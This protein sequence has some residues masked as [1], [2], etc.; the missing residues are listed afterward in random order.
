MTMTKE[1]G[2]V[3]F[4]GGVNGVGKSSFLQELSVRHPEFEI[5][6]GSTKFMECLGIEPGDY[7]TM[8][9]LPDDYKNKE[10]DK[11]MRWVLENGVLSEKTLIIDAHYYNYK[12]GE[13][14][15]ATGDWIS[16]LD[17]LFV[18]S[19]S[20]ATILRRVELDEIRSGHKR[21]LL[22]FEAE[23]S[24]KIELLDKFLRMT[25]DKAR[26]LSEK[27]G[28]PYFVINN[29]A[30]GVDLAVDEFLKYHSATR[31]VQK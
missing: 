14:I 23:E 15:N 16:L 8:R 21:D 11:M 10:L 26:E 13:M 24:Q 1:R 5:F 7:E 22:P 29:D 17:A 18:V 9:K 2:N 31:S 30:E 4:V 6:R 28:I 25:I 20:P 3:Y 19:A 27:Y 12:R